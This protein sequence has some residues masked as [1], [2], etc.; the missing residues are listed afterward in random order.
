MPSCE[1]FGLATLCPKCFATIMRLIRRGADG[2]QCVPATYHT[3]QQTKR[4]VWFLHLWHSASCVFI[5]L[6]HSVS[7]VLKNWTCR[8]SYMQD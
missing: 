5:R 7:E 6:K 2:T 8:S 4:S 3:P 1:R